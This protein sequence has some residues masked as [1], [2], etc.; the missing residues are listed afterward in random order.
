MKSQESSDG[1]VVSFEFHGV[2]GRFAGTGPNVA[3]L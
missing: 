3:N 2:R 1:K